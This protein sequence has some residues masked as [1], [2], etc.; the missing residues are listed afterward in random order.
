MERRVYMDGLDTARFSCSGCGREKTMQL[1][2]YDI[3]KN[4]TRIKLKCGCGTVQT[5]LL[6]KAQDAQRSVQLLGTYISRDEVQ[7]AGKMTIKKVNSRGLTLK[8]NIEQKI[9][10]GLKLFLEFVLDDAKQSIVKREVVVRARKGQYLTAEFTSAQH[11]D[12][13]G[14]YLYSHGLYI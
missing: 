1:S 13:L 2:A 12:N 3:Q 10:S 6:E 14:P 5:L 7:C 11:H 4:I 8:T 9:S